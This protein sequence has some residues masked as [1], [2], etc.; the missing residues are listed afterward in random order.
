MD[1]WRGRREKGGRG[2]GG[3]S[4]RTVEM[5]RKRPPRELNRDRGRGRLTLDVSE[6]S[7]KVLG[8][9]WTEGEGE[10]R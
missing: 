5:R 9:G 7:R 2:R 1:E 4:R 6:V 10:G 8:H 3:F